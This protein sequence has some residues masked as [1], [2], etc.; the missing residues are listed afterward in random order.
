[1]VNSNETAEMQKMV[2]YSLRGLIYLT[3][4]FCAKARRHCPSGKR[5]VQ[6]GGEPNSH[7]ASG[8]WDV[9]DSD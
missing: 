6:A 8:D 7:P 4:R 9:R 2:S 5:K 1:M 3:D